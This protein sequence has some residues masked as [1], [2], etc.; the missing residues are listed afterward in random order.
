MPIEIR[1]PQIASDMT[2]A[3]LLAWLVE[4][5]AAV[6]AGEVL[7]EIETDKSTVEVESPATGTLAEI[8]VPGG[9][10]AVK[11]GELL[12]RIETAERADAAAEPPAHG[13]A[14]PARVEPPAP[15]SSRRGDSAPLEGVSEPEPPSAADA[16][17]GTGADSATGAY[18]T[19]LARRIADQ[20]GLSLASVEGSGARG[21]VM[22]EDVERALSFSS[23]S[24]SVAQAE[25]S[26]APASADGAERS[27]LSRGRRPG[28]ERQVAQEHETPLPYHLSVECRADELMAA[29]QHINETGHEP[30]I[31]INDLIVRACALALREVP[32][33][34]ATWDGDAILRHSSVDVAVAVAT[35]GGLVTP[36]VRDADRKGLAALTAELRALAERARAGALDPSECEGGGLG[37]SNLAMYGID[38]A[39]FV[40]DA[41]WSCIL[42]V[43]AARTLPLVVD[44]EIRVG[45]CLTLTLSADR[46]AVD[47]ALGATLLSA[48]KRRV[49]R[50]LEMVL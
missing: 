20:A 30:R 33:A 42:G 31:S 15:Q 34:N 38:S 48:I 19:A 35:D 23:P 41:P 45:R 10:Q 1:M 21:R 2:E 12:G 22:R 46:R 5:G 25:G 7:L 13:P 9:S 47:G 29:R 24:S 40:V 28:A 3:D 18:A 39:T 8:L 11:V 50:P 43:G 14:A 36:V 44:G 4:P 17:P 26:G 32:D 37:V 6:V 49:E 27:A 16:G